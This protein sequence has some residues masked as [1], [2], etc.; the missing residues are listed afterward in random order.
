MMATLKV[1]L[2]MG[3]LIGLLYG[4][5]MLLN[6]HPVLA[7]MFALVPNLIAYFYSDK[8]VLMSY[9]AKIVDEHEFPTLHRIVE[10]IANKAGI[11]KPKIAIVDTPTPNAF[12]TGRSPKNAVVAVTTGILS[13]LSKEELEGVIAHEIS[14]IKHRDILVSTIVATMAGAIVYIANW[15]QWGMFFGFGQDD[16]DNPVHLIGTLL[17]IFLAPIAATLVQFAISRQREYFADEDGAKLSNPYYLANALSKLE[18]G[19]RYHPME[20]GNPATEHMFIVNPFKGDTLIKLFSTHP[21]TEERIR[22]L[23][24]MARNPRYLG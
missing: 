5:F 10:K 16:E 13:L 22:R 17:F 20:K 11:P 23:M 12:A 9:G 19:V 6:I 4:A 8:L 21:P 2:L 15:L 3:V 14:H 18:K 1:I 24:E 7:I